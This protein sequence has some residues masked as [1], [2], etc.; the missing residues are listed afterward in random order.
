MY[1][2]DD[3][4]K[5]AELVKAVISFANTAGGTIF[6]GV[7]D[8]AEVEGIEAHIPHDKRKAETFESDYFSKIRTLL[9]QKLNRIPVMEI[10]KERIGDKTVF[11]I[12][13]EEG[14]AKPYFNI[15]T[16]E[17]FVRR[18]ASDIRPNPDADIRQM[19]NSEK[20]SGFDQF[21]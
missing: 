3:K 16:N 18:G 11:I 7:T 15:Q 17:M 9:Q 10:R 13:V 2:L 4:K 6:I 5:A 1:R 20:L 19:M 8:D 12:Q 21:D 14:G